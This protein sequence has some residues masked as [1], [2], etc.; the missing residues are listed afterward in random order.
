MKDRYYVIT[1]IIYLVVVITCIV[2]ILVLPFGVP[3]SG[4]GQDATNAIVSG[5]SYFED[6]IEAIK[7]K[8]FGS[9]DS[10]RVFYH[11]AKCVFP[12]YILIISTILIF[13]KKYLIN[14][15][16]VSILLVSGIMTLATW[17]YPYPG[18]Y[19]WPILLAISIVAFVH[20]KKHAPPAVDERELHIKDE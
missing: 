7:K 18:S 8:G 2:F 16:L 20:Q 14:L 17:H 6:M 19:F 11:H 3:R 12:F 4:N 9:V 5:Y 10:W 15:I 1:S 13:F